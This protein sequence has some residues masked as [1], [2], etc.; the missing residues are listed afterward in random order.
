MA[1]GSLAPAV[2]LSRGL[3]GD[4]LGSTLD[5]LQGLDAGIAWGLFSQSQGMTVNAL[6]RWLAWGVFAAPGISVSETP[7]ASDHS[8]L[9]GYVLAPRRAQ[10]PVFG[11][12]AQRV[13]RWEYSGLKPEN[14][15]PEPSRFVLQAESAE[16]WADLP[17]LLA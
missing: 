2:L 17:A 10:S 16:F 14:P 7:L 11:Q 12:S 9:S 5:A 15:Q 8:R 13:R 4:L 1:A 3:A 6:Y